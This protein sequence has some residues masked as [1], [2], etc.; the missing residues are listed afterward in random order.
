MG[1]I[2]I[3]NIEY[4][5][6]VDKRFA[7]CEFCDVRIKDYDYF[8]EHCLLRKTGNRPCGK[9]IYLKRVT[10]TKEVFEKKVKEL[11][12]RLAG[13]ESYLAICIDLTIEKGEFKQSFFNV[14]RL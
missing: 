10:I 3:N 6:D 14:D 5:D 11:A 12:L 4:T 7:G 1:T 13:K 9:A 8:K 2:L